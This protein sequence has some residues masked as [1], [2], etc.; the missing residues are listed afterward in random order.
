MSLYEFMS[1][2]VYLV[3]VDV[4]E[5]EEV[6]LDPEVLGLIALEGFMRELAIGFGAIATPKVVLAL[7]VG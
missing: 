7:V 3:L 6:V 4:N 5:V 2:C 1:V